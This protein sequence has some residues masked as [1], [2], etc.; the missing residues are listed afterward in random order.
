MRRHAAADRVQPSELAFWLTLV[1]VFSLWVS[2]ACMPRGEPRVMQRRT[3]PARPWAAHR[4]A[5]AYKRIGRR[6]GAFFFGAT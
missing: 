5:V 2:L 3:T 6:G 1:A 4:D